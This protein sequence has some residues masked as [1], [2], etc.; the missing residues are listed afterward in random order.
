MPLF[1]FHFKLH[2]FLH[3]LP[4]DLAP[5]LSSSFLVDPATIQSDSSV[6]QSFFA[7]PFFF[8]LDRF[9]LVSFLLCALLLF[10]AD[11]LGFLLAWL[12]HHPLLLHQNWNFWHESLYSPAEES[13]SGLSLK[14]SVSHMY[15]GLILSRHPK[16]ESSSSKNSKDSRPLPVALLLSLIFLYLSTRLFHF[17][18]SCVNVFLLSIPLSWQLSLNAC[19][20]VCHMAFF[21]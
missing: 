15:L 10:S 3:N 1:G 2:Q 11:L 6:R 17:S 16:K 9:L 4:S 7:F 21:L 18:F 8:D 13:L 5:L 12:C 14:I 19:R 20:I